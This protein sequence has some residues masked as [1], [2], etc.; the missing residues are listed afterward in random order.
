M[1]DVYSLKTN[2]QKMRTVFCLSILSISLLQCMTK[3]HL[4]KIE[5]LAGLYYQT[6]NKIFELVLDS[7]SSFLYYLPNGAWGREFGCC[8]T[9]TYGKWAYGPK[10]MIT[11]TSPTFLTRRLNILVGESANSNTDTVYIII[12]NPIEDYLSRLGSLPRTIQYTAG[13]MTADG[14]GSFLQPTESKKGS[15]ILKF[16][17]PNRAPLQYLHIIAF[18][19]P[20]SSDI[21]LDDMYNE[22]PKAVETDTYLIKD[23]FANRFD[24]VIPH[25]TFGFMRFRR[26][27]QDYVEIINRNRLKWNGHEF[28][29]KRPYSP[30]Q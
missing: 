10:G 24:I 2:V 12:N 20:N 9:V 3:N 25:L 16:Y 11:L 19:K 30:P 1:K 5:N 27:N 7:N 17:N 13:L 28:I 21:L 6:D 14:S 22:G 15:N 18:F 4:S 23:K 8:D 29:R 26:V